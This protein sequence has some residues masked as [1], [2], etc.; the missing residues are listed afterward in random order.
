[1]SYPTPQTPDKTHLSH[2]VTPRLDPGTGPDQVQNLPKHRRCGLDVWLRSK[3]H[4]SI[5]YFHTIFIITQLQ[6]F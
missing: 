3:S 6:F 1:M 5:Y 2:F 4:F